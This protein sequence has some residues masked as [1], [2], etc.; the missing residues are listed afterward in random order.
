MSAFVIALVPYLIGQMVCPGISGR[1]TVAV[2]I[3]CALW[4]IPVLYLIHDACSCAS[5]PYWRVMIVSALTGSLIG[6][7]VPTWRRRPLTTVSWYERFKVVVTTRTDQESGVVATIDVFSPQ[8][9]GVPRQR[10]EQLP[11]VEATTTD[12]AIAEAVRS[13][14]AWINAR[15][16]LG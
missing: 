12:D 10:A 13:A 7:F 4:S 2:A 11:S 1:E 16:Q 14:R 9:P 15:Q 3:G 6:F 5:P 8:V